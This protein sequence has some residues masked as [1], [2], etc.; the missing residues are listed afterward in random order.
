MV[1]GGS[2]ATVL[3]GWI[4]GGGAAVGAG[5]GGQATDVL[6]V[7]GSTGTGGSVV[8]GIGLGIACD[9]DVAMGVDIGV[10]SVGVTV[11]CLGWAG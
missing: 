7:A 2:L 1:A 11:G 8:V 5:D 10:A 6:T 9:G 4:D 3:G